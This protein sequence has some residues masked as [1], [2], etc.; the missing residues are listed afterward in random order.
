[1]VGQYSGLLTTQRPVLQTA[2]HYKSFEEVEQQIVWQSKIG[3]G[4]GK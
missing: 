1:L 3:I 2:M 4:N